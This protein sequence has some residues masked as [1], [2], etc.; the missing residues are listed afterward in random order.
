MPPTFLLLIIRAIGIPFM[1][2][3]SV[4]TLLAIYGR[5]A[6]LRVWPRKNSN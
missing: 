3:G 2:A 5:K 4:L 1:I 6:I